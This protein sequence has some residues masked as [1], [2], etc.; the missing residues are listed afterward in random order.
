M[1]DRPQ[2]RDYL[3]G[4]LAVFSFCSLG[5]NLLFIFQ[6]FH[7]SFWHDLR[8]SF[9]HPPAVSASDHQR[10]NPGA[11]VTIIEY[12][13]FQCHFCREMHETLRTA[14]DQGEI[15]WIFGNAPIISIHPKAFEA[16]VAAEC[17][18]AQGRFWE[19]S[20]ALF[21]AQGRLDSSSELEQEL[22][23]LAVQSSADQEKLRTCI[24]SGEFNALVNRQIADAEAIRI[25]A[26]PTV[27][28]NNKRHRGMM[29][30]DELKPWLAPHAN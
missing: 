17:A 21:D 19:Y 4:F 8:L 12:S 9:L 10:G 1:T 30:Y 14:A 15:R 27:F 20:D 25:E 29:S 5:L 7:P 18:G 11:H 13:D 24:H 3:L 16:A 26:T 22:M 28:I 23:H 2:R 6:L